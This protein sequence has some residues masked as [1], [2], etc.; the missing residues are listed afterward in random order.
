MV[1]SGAGSSPLARGLRAH[2][3][4]RDRLDRIIPARAGFT[5]EEQHV[6]V[7]IEDHPRSRGVYDYVTRDFMR[8]PGSSPLARGLL[9]G[10]LRIRRP[11]RII[12]ARAGFTLRIRRPRIGTQDH[13]RSRGVYCYRAAYFV[14][15]PGSSPLARGLQVCISV[16]GS[17]NGI[18]P[19]RAGFTRRLARAPRRRPDHPRSRG[20]YV[21]AVLGPVER[22]GSS[23]LARGLRSRDSFSV[24]L[25][26]IIPARAGFTP[27]R[28]TGFTT[29]AGSSPLARGLLRQR[30]TQTIRTRI[31][32]A[33]AGFT[34]RL[35]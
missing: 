9:D 31:I 2:R 3:P 18:I 11:R 30:P 1:S 28:R 27:R 24:F 25:P 22:R 29:H 33:R 10:L 35:S 12:P 20:V 7:D 26:G 13:P 4:I 14:L 21:R 19:A 17:D 15:N 5:G 32:P 34:S 8:K 6:R 23:P 16:R